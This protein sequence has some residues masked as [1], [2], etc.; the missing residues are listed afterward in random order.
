MKLTILKCAN[1]KQIVKVDVIFLS[2]R[3]PEDCYGHCYWLCHHG[4]HWIFRQ[5]HPHPHQ[6]HHCW[7][8][9]G[10]VI[11]QSE[12]IPK[13]WYI[14]CNGSKK[15]MKNKIVYS[16]MNGLIIRNKSIELQCT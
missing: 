3:I 8:I 5:A 11:N 1:A 10:S 6:Q 7:I 4:F 9:V 13:V 16:L 12:R 15:H 14:V 2:F